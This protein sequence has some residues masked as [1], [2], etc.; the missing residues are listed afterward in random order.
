MVD[1][2]D[3]GGS[4]EQEG[5]TVTGRSVDNLAIRM[6]WVS[7]SSASSLANTSDIC[8]S[9]F[10]LICSSLSIANP[11]DKSNVDSG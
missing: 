10:S 5:G 9:N 3:S 2:M 11:Y 6:D 8:F 4:D 1:G 7:F